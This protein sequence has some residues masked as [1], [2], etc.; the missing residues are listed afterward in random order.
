LLREDKKKVIIDNHG[1]EKYF[2]MLD[3]LD[4]PERISLTQS[5]ILPNFLAEAISNTLQEA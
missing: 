5:V 3:S 2:D 4:H 1:E